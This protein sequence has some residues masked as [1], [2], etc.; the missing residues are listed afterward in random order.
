MHPRIHEFI[1][2]FICAEKKKNEI[3]TECNVVTHFTELL[4]T[5]QTATLGCL[6]KK[7]CSKRWPSHQTPFQTPIHQHNVVPVTYL[8]NSCFAV[9]SLELATGCPM[10]GINAFAQHILSSFS[11]FF[12]TSSSFRSPFLS[13]F[14][15][16][17]NQLGLAVFVYRMKNFSH[18][19]SI[20][21]RLMPKL[22]FTLISTVTLF[23][24][25]CKRVC[26]LHIKSGK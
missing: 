9:K 15:F 23:K 8:G 25:H 26:V 22:A 6:S 10:V 17:P 1:Q 4:C 2:S 18:G 21:I 11:S 12:H 7:L 5:L 3:A 20:T 13:L 19:F 24:F 14:R 16:S